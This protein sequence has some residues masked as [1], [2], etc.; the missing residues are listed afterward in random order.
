[1]D[2]SVQPTLSPPRDFFPGFNPNSSEEKWLEETLKASRSPAGQRGQDSSRHTPS[3]A[4]RQLFNP[5]P[6][7]PLAA[8]R[9]RTLPEPLHCSEAQVL[10]VPCFPRPPS[11]QRTIERPCYEFPRFLGASKLIPFGNQQL[12]RRVLYPCVGH[13]PDH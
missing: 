12:R 5:S 1:M 9:Q 3:S 11:A 8:A 7:P 10:V 13:M 6:S 2:A 4:T